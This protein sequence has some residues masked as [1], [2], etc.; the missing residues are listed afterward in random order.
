MNL[1]HMCLN[2]HINFAIIIIYIIPAETLRDSTLPPEDR[3]KNAQ[4]HAYHM[5]L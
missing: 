1:M 3:E 2:K 4:C 5:Y